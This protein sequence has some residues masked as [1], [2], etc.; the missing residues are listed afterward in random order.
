MA[1]P[2]FSKTSSSK[3]SSANSSPNPDDS[4][5]GSAQSNSNE[6][7]LSPNNR[8]SHKK[9]NKHKNK[10][11]AKATKNM[12]C[13]IQ[14]S[15]GKDDELTAA[16][17]ERAKKEEE[18]EAKIRE[19]FS[20][21]KGAETSKSVE[22][23]P[24]TSESSGGRMDTPLPTPTPTPKL[25]QEAPN[26]PTP[27]GTPCQQAQAA[28]DT[29]TPASNAG[30]QPQTA[31]TTP[32]KTTASPACAESSTNPPPRG[33]KFSPEAAPFT[34]RRGNTTQRTSNTLFPP[35]PRPEFL[36]THH[37]TFASTRGYML[38]ETQ[39]TPF[40]SEHE[41]IEESKR[42]IEEAKQKE[43]NAKAKTTTPKKEFKGHDMTMPDS[44][45][46]RREVAQP[47]P[48]VTGGRD[49]RVSSGPTPPRAGVG[50]GVGS[51]GPPQMGNLKERIVSSG[52]PALAT[53]TSFYGGNGQYGSGGKAKERAPPES[54]ILAGFYP[55]GQLKRDGSGSASITPAVTQTV[56]TKA[57]SI[58]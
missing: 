48:A 6:R 15:C 27:S 28:P 42:L 9:A 22:C 19:I 34:I 45:Y 7:E 3:T 8:F 47:A 18:K 31:P 50:L 56:S 53:G 46:R 16:Q 17:R 36:C 54:S 13:E 10:G 52:A 26:T 37:Q 32:T 38:S 33:F 35:G 2:I 44:R 25:D 14:G 49:S 43:A 29:T 5:N 58:C 24:T 12:V 20:P 51:V 4:P 40:L 1:Y 11:K 23:S 39:K 30:Q 57:L 41:A 21:S 55:T